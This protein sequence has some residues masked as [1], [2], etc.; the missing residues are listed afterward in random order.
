MFT[1]TLEC[2]QMNELEDV[3]NKCL[4]KP[5]T[6]LPSGN[7]LVG[8]FHS[9]S[10]LPRCYANV[11]STLAKNWL[12]LWKVASIIILEQRLAATSS[13]TIGRSSLNK[14][15]PQLLKLLVEFFHLWSSHKKSWST[16]QSHLHSLLHLPA[17][18][19]NMNMHGTMQLLCLYVETLCW[20]HWI[21]KHYS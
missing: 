1:N 13:K 11:G 7:H 15:S 10:L 6:L 14:A 5:W 3:H 20:W 17:H 4:F 12:V 21:C 19:S 9:F 2:H 18:T 16:S 8:V